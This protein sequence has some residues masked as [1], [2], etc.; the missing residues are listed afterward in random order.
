MIHFAQMVAEVDGT[1]RKR[2]KCNHT[3]THL[4]QAAL[5]QVLPNDVAQQG[6]SVT[7]D[8]LRFDFNLDRPMKVTLEILRRITMDV[9]SC[10]VMSSSI[11]GIVRFL[12]YLL[13]AASRKV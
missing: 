3:A 2:S 5:K 13:V 9:L 12:A 1:M 4:L 7:F 8:S 10:V 11:R 6:S